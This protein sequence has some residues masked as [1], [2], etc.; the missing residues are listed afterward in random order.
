M[1]PHDEEPVKDVRLRD[2][3]KLVIARR[4]F[5]SRWVYGQYWHGGR[6]YAVFGGGVHRPMFIHFDGQWYALAFGELSRLRRRR[7]GAWL[8]HAAHPA[9]PSGPGEFE[10][11]LS[12]E[13]MQYLLHHC[14]LPPPAGIKRLLAVSPEA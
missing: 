10:A 12:D 2:V 1:L 5:Y 8:Y 6:M 9:W 11:V 7:Q 3:R 14:D 13:D 4:S